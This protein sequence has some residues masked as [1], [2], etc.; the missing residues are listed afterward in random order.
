MWIHSE[1][2]VT[3]FINK[4]YFLKK[5]LIQNFKPLKYGFTD[6]YSKSVQIKHRI[7]LTLVIK[8]H[9]YKCIIQLN[10]EVEYM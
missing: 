3:N 9:T 5:H 2:N 8:Q 6:Q 1:H 7:I 10:L 4:L